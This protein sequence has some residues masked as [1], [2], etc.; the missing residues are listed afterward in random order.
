[1][2]RR[3]SF[4]L[5]LT[6]LPALAQAPTTAAAV[7]ADARKKIR[8][9]LVWVWEKGNA[10]CLKVER[11][12]WQA[13]P[14]KA[15]LRDFILWRADIELFKD[16]EALKDV[17]RWKGLTQGAV[18]LNDL[19]ILHP[20]GA[21]LYR[22]EGSTVTTAS[23]DRIEGV[24]KDVLVQWEARQGPIRKDVQALETALKGRDL[25]K[26]AACAEQVV[27]HHEGWTVPTLAS[28]LPKPSLKVRQVILPELRKIDQE[29]GIQALMGWL[30]SSP[31]VEGA[32]LA[33]KELEAAADPRSVTLLK[34]NLLGNPA[35]ATVRLRALGKIRDKA[36]IPYLIDL[37]PKFNAPADP[38]PGDAHAAMR[39]EAVASLRLLTARD[40]GND[41][42]AWKDWWATDGA[43]F[44]FPR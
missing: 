41:A 16:P 24:L 27:R 10:D 33:W 25:E 17:P 14:L 28:A 30:K 29:D 11:E 23:A 3:I 2:I 7:E 40:F 35:V 44:E 38:Q 34:D 31:A 12:R 6:A 39:D 37:M 36:T 1:M 5:L 32:E 22:L 42:A 9:V 21:E 13:D 8:P 26:I 43:A 4:A 18:Q 15:R 19:I 20:W